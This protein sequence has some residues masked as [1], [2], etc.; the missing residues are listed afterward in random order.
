MRLHY[1]NQKYVYQ[2]LTD[3]DITHIPLKKKIWKNN[4]IISTPQST[5]DVTTDIV[6]YV[7]WGKI[8]K[9]FRTC[10]YVVLRLLKAL[11]FIS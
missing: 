3:F 2:H 7:L 5:L 8:C 11:D 10:M 6:A 1:L 9:S 4:P